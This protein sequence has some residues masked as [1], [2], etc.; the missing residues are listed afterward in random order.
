MYIDRVNAMIG[1][2]ERIREQMRLDKKNKKNF[3]VGF[4]LGTWADTPKDNNDNYCG[5]TCCAIGHATLDPYFQKNGLRMIFEY[6][7]NYREEWKS[8]PVHNVNDLDYYKF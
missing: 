8:K 2:L 6:K 4:D 3:V 1:F 7:N 5:T